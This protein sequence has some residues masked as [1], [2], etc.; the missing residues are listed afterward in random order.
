M[1]QDDA[2]IAA[3]NR[4]RRRR[5]ADAH[6]HEDVDDVVEVESSSSASPAPVQVSPSDEVDSSP[7]HSPLDTDDSTDSEFFEGSDVD[8]VNA[9][10]LDAS[11]AIRQLFTK[12]GFTREAMSDTL[13][14]FRAFRPDLQLSIDPR[15]LMH[16]PTSLPV[17]QDEKGEIV[18]FD[19]VPMVS[20][21]KKLDNIKMIQIN[22]DGV[23]L[24]NNSKIQAWF[25][26]VRFVGEQVNSKPLPISLFVG[27]E[28]PNH[29]RFFLHMR[30]F[31]ASVQGTDICYIFDAPAR[32]FAKGTV[33]HGHTSACERCE[34]EGEWIGRMTYPVVRSRPRTGTWDEAVAKRKFCQKKGLKAEAPTDEDLTGPQRRRL[35]KRRADT[36]T[37]ESEKEND[38]CFVIVNDKEPRRKKR[39]GGNEENPLPRPPPARKFPLVSTPPA[40]EFPL[41]SS[42]P[43]SS[44]SLTL[45]A[46]STPVP[47]SAPI[48]TPSLQDSQLYGRKLAA[49]F[50]LD[51][52]RVER[53]ATLIRKAGVEYAMA[54]QVIQQLTRPEP[55]RNL[56]PVR[57]AN[58]LAVPVGYSDTKVGS[59]LGALLS[60]RLSM[61]IKMT[62]L[63]TAVIDAIVGRFDPRLLDPD[64]SSVGCFDP[65]SFDPGL[66]DPRRVVAPLTVAFLPNPA[67]WWPH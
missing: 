50:Q 51:P 4:R 45:T 31:V 54:I 61:T 13:R 63:P 66:L 25:V 27:R 3:Q 18:D 58:S 33:Q 20:E 9:E 55:S 65:G 46:K 40:R 8:E 44:R 53:T 36:S 5:Y 43:V 37:S 48:P 42:T 30:N 38:D 17:F 57:Q 26:Q 15:T 6:G 19:V 62:H 22:G 35:M 49:M 67:E 1:N 28:K 24:Y 29:E 32:A 14:L 11:S 56:A 34:C 7:Y 12:H 41:V 16:T 23:P 10:E 47:K 2:R 64:D 60:R 52:E 21:F 39:L 59:I